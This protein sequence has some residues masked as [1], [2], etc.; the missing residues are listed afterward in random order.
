MPI[1]PNE[2]FEEVKLFNSN[3]ANVFNSVDRDVYVSGGEIPAES[4]K[5]IG[6]KKLDHAVDP[7]NITGDLDVQKYMIETYE[8]I[9]KLCSSH[10]VSIVFDELVDDRI[11]KSVAYLDYMEQPD[12]SVPFKLPF[13]MC[14]AAP[15]TRTF[16][17]TFG[18]FKYDTSIVCVGIS[19]L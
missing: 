12:A 15:S 18:V 17:L 7:L 8:N 5:C 6:Y 11:Y 14:N 16:T 3:A 2:K 13:F 1:L 19:T 9:E 4:F 10:S